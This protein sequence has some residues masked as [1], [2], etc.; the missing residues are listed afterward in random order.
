LGENSSDVLLTRLRLKRRT[1][2]NS[3][4]RNHKEKEMADF[5]KW[6]LAF[7][8]VALLSS[9]ALPVTAQ[10][11]SA[12]TCIAT[13]GVPPV[14]RAEG[15]AD[16][17]GDVVLSCNGGNPALGIQAVNIQV[18]MNAFVTSRLQSNGLTD[19]LVLIGEP[20]AGALKLCPANS[21]ICST[22]ATYNAFQGQ[23]QNLQTSS[24]GTQGYTSVVWTGV[25]FVPPGTNNTT[26]IRITN[27]RTDNLSAPPAAG[28]FIPQT[29]QEFVSI[30][31]VH[32][33]PITNPQ[34]TVAFLQPALSLASLG[35]GNFV[36]C[37]GQNVNLLTNKGPGD[38]TQF[39]LLLTEG[40]A[41]SFKLIGT[42][43]QSTPGVNNFSEN[44][45]TSLLGFPGTTIGQ[46]TQ[47]TRFFVNIAGVQSGVSVYLPTSVPLFRANDG[48]VTGSAKLVTCDSTGTTCTNASPTTN[49][50][51][52]STAATAFSGSAKIAL[53]A[54]FPGTI[55][56]SLVS[57]A[58]Q[59]FYEV[60]ADDP[61]TVESVAIPT[62]FA[63][64]SGLP[65]IPNNPAPTVSV[66]LAPQN[67]DTLALATDP[68][69]RFGPSTAAASTLPFNI[70]A[71][72]CNLLF[73]YVTSRFNYDT[74]IAV[75]NT[76]MDPFVGTVSQHG[77]VTFHFYGSTFDASNNSVPL[78][79]TQQTGVSPDVAAGTTYAFSIYSGDTANGAT[80]NPLANFS[81]YVIATANFQY[82]HGLAF[83][84][85]FGR[86]AY[87]QGASESYLGLVIGQPTVTRGP[88]GEVLGH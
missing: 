69:P 25:P 58:G 76:S 50:T 15:V 75:S 22:D 48:K 19:A 7:A 8:V 81:G 29:I 60:T 45:F 55:N 87:D 3:K 63:F 18:F 10:T 27:I 49:N 42:N 20:A 85:G 51:F 17:V 54:A 32:G 13:S 41:S 57:T 1:S 80:V 24:N 71:C 86:G 73:T 33:F 12:V 66:G 39:G 47:A 11:T 37:A 78:T 65:V 30:T 5:R 52:G 40:F 2:I 43:E 64:N 79:A 74:G 35:T 23:L 56:L 70:N 38:I 84:S 14:V 68:I 21:T 46:A 61:F 53:N 83:I 36:Q 44:G 82:C 4:L 77:V 26:T 28:Q 67:T 72:T 34:L 9:L 62:L 6:F 31:G 88:G 16:L 59:I